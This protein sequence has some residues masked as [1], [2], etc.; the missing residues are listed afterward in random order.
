MRRS[1]GGAGNQKSHDGY[2]RRPAKPCR[3]GITVV[4]SICF[5]ETASRV[6]R[7]LEARRTCQLFYAAPTT[8][9]SRHPRTTPDSG[10]HEKTGLFDVRLV[11]AGISQKPAC[12]SSVLSVPAAQILPNAGNPNP[13]QNTFLA[14]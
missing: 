11:D 10:A 14:F 9:K 3:I 5:T 13:G 8:G 6:Y 1:G 7:T 12:C 2:R 4:S